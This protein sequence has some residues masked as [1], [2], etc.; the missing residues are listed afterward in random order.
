[1]VTTLQTPNITP[2]E[3]NRLAR[4]SGAPMMMDPHRGKKLTLEMEINEESSTIKESNTAKCST[5][6]EFFDER[7]ASHT[8]TV[9]SGFNDG[10]IVSQIRHSNGTIGGIV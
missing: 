1:M 4:L 10:G 9:I 7:A 3:A 6:D 8:R 2:E 5:A